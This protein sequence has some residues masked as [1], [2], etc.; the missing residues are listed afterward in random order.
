M[1]IFGEDQKRA[2][3]HVD[4]R[5]KVLTTI[6]IVGVSPI[7]IAIV[8]VSPIYIAIST[9]QHD[10]YCDIYSWSNSCIGNYILQLIAIQ[11]IASWAWLLAS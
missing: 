9:V 11:L 7:T 3:K 8:G 10:I 4:T 2:G 6:A 1:E 5:K